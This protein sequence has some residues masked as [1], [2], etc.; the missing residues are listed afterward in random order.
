MRLVTWWSEEQ[1]AL[2]LG[3]TLYTLRTCSEICFF[4]TE[5]RKQMWFS[6][7]LD[8]RILYTLYEKWGFCCLFRL[9]S[10]RCWDSVAWFLCH[11]QLVCGEMICSCICFTFLHWLYC[12]QKGRNGL[13]SMRAT[14]ENMTVC[15]GQQVL[16]TILGW[17]FLLDVKYLPLV[18]LLTSSPAGNSLGT[19]R[20]MSWINQLLDRL[21][22]SWAAR[23]KM[24]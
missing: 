8:N 17:V 19:W 2:L 23:L 21:R 18:R 10:Q 6:L 3:P 13:T 14:W 5:I 15:T 11:V 4:I 1:K 24:S 7:D 16:F 12:L 20:H 9:L 22:I